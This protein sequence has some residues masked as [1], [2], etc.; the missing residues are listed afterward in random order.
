M[1]ARRARGTAS[2]LAFARI[3]HRRQRRRQLYLLAEARALDRS[4]AR[5]PRQE[6]CTLVKKQ[7]P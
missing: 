7:E 1:T 5:N 2:G 4:L 3:K 6:S